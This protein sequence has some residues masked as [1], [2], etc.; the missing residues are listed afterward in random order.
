MFSKKD[1]DKE[2][3]FLEMLD[4]YDAVIRRVCFMYTGISADFEDLY[5]ETMANLWRGMGSFRGESRMSTW[6][7]RCAV[8]TCLSYLRSTRRH[9]HADLDAALTMV[10]GDDSERQEQL[11]SLYAVISQLDPLERALI[12]MWLDSYNYDEI[13]EVTGL[14]PNNIGVRLH[15]IRAKLKDRL[16]G[17]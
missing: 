10:A 6:I 2:S 1:I 14:S 13:A 16:S 12:V 17:Q 8:N 5:Q 15:R 7:Y 11:C 3:R 9:T 4:K